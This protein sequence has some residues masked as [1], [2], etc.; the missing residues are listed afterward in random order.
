M[1]YHSLENCNIQVS[2]SGVIIT[3]TI[4]GY[5][6]GVIYKVDYNIRT[7]GNWETLDF[8]IRSKQNDEV[9]LISF[10]G[11]GLGNWKRNGEKLEQFNG[12]LDIDIPLTPFTNSLPINRLKL[13]NNRPQEINVIYLDLLSYEI[14]RVK[15]KYV[16]L[17]AFEYRYE[18]VPN[19]FETV[20]KVDE[21]GF[22]LDYPFLFVQTAAYTKP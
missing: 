1:Q 15:Q 14:R 17:S 10:E 12:C 19:D 9:Q 5:Y 8:Q 16:R 11:D 22:V 3:S 18:N 13:V 6:E 4:V 20:I 2:E 7:N 21:A